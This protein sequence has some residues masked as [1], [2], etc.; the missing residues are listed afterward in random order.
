MK[1]LYLIGG[2]GGGGKLKRGPKTPTIKGKHKTKKISPTL[3]NLNNG[4]LVILGK[5]EINL[6]A[7]YFPDPCIRSVLLLPFAA[8][9]LLEMEG[10][11]PWSHCFVTPSK[12][13][14]SEVFH[15]LFE[16][17]SIQNQNSS[18]K[19]A[20]FCGVTL[21]LRLRIKVSEKHDESQWF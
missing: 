8:T 3:P 13:L 11:P 7:K 12:H 5:I 18:M 4:L 20:V 19:N 17:P 10:A 16:D 14:P 21:S 15:D 9:T 6:K 1:N 2:K